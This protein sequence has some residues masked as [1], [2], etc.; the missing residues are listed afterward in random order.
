[1]A[2]SARGGD[3][4]SDSR[5]PPWTCHSE[6]ANN[7]RDLQ[8]L[9]SSGLPIPI[10]SV[11]SCAQMSCVCARFDALTNSF[12]ITSSRKKIIERWGVVSASRS[13]KSIVVTALAACSVTA[14]VAALR[15]P[16]ATQ[17]TGKA[18]MPDDVPKTCPITKPPRSP[19]VPPAPYPAKTDPHC[20]WF[21]T[22][23]LWTQLG[24]DGRWRGLP[25]YTPD[26]PTFRQK[27]FWWRQ[28]YDVR[29]EPQPK[30]PVTGMRPDSSA[31]PVLLADRA[32]NAWSKKTS[33]LW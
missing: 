5:V 3:R 23:K 14:I 20:F 7:R 21:A 18:A 2:K 8:F 24:T 12:A 29:S 9:G 10:P 4:D 15:A 26:D 19:F 16:A 17:A 27:L 32:S 1:M 30:L 25:H 6:I 33:H 22:E 13:A 28:G 31:P 11:T